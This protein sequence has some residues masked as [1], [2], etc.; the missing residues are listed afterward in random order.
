MM[1]IVNVCV[2][3]YTTPVL[4]INGFGQRCHSYD[5]QMCCYEVSSLIT[6]PFSANST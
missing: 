6:N 4:L 3:L 1:K 2:N 5:S